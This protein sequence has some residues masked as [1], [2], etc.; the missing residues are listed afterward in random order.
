MAYLNV[1]L[2]RSWHAHVYFDAATR[3]PAWEFREAVIAHFGDAIER[4]GF[5]ERPVG[6]HPKWKLRQQLHSLGGSGRARVPIA[7]TLQHIEACPLRGVASR[8]QTSSKLTLPIP[9]LQAKR[10]AQPHAIPCGGL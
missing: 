1:S 8:R 3:A 5:H 9:A 7:R 10:E 6:S 2:I 4:G